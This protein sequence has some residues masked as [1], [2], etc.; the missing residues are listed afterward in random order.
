MKGETVRMLRRNE[1]LTQEELANKIGV[2]PSTVRMIESGKRAGNSDTA[3]RLADFFSVTVAYLECDNSD[4]LATN[5]HDHLT[6]FLNLL[7]ESG[8]IQDT[9]D[10][11]KTTEQLIL[12][13]VKQYIDTLLALKKDK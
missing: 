5:R 11:N 13:Q 4:I 10:I 12:T 3:K 1:G 9:N 2:S 8:A 6:N 7:I